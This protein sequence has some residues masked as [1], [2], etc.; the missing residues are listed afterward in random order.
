MKQAVDG[1]IIPVE[2]SGHSG[3]VSNGTD[4]DIT[5][6]QN[7]M[8]TGNP[9]L[10]DQLMRGFIVECRVQATKLAKTRELQEELFSEGM[11]GAL[12]CLPRFELE[13]ETKL[14]TFVSFRIRGSMLDFLRGQS[15][16]NGLPRSVYEMREKIREI[17]QRA[18]GPLSDD[19]VT[20]QLV[21]LGCPLDRIK[22][23][24]L[25]RPDLNIDDPIGEDGLVLGDIIPSDD[26]SV[27]DEMGSK[28]K[29]EI[30]SQFIDSLPENQAQILHLY[31]DSELPMHEIGDRMNVT[32][33]RICQLH[34][35]AIIALREKM[36]AINGGWDSE[37]FV[38]D[39]FNTGKFQEWFKG[40]FR[41]DGRRVFAAG[42][43][44]LGTDFSLPEI[45]DSSGARSVSTCL[46]RGFSSKKLAIHQKLVGR[47][48]LKAVDLKKRNVREQIRQ[49]IFKKYQIE[50]NFS[51]FPP[52]PRNNNMQEIFKSPDFEGWFRKL[53]GARGGVAF[54]AALLF[55]RTDIKLV[56]IG[57]ELNV[58]N[59]SILVRHA[60][61]GKRGV[62]ENLLH[63]SPGSR[64]SLRTY[65]A[66]EKVR[67]IILDRYQKKTGLRLE[68]IPDLPR[69]KLE[70][71]FQNKAQNLY[72]PDNNI[73]IK[74]VR[75]GELEDKEAASV[76][77]ALEFEP[78]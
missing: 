7:W 40:L 49:S 17:R 2:L 48:D 18:E 69:E 16:Q 1:N 67:R 54:Q 46:K 42:L 64:V 9:E 66:K 13:K 71:S 26:V 32:E 41:K 59:A 51:D 11:M 39:I 38:K 52:L 37:S 19:E 4:P 58:K 77:S 25:W 36:N 6:W 68:E 27:L 33:S 3:S 55:L 56:Q 23:A 44:Y 76:T 12:Q 74:S 65:E 73:S 22:R 34:G 29:S 57:R 62:P 43:L 53:F 10:L 5:L 31:Y 50:T 14:K 63:G 20:E 45:E 8:D 35:Q 28:Q 72:G 47:K 15:N 60:L 78:V 61:G 70:V 24:M 21:A 30:L 75:G